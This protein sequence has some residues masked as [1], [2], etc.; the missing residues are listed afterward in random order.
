MNR[1]VDERGAA[2]SLSPIKTT[3]ERSAGSENHLLGAPPTT[4]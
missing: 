3:I 1:R 4:L 2:F